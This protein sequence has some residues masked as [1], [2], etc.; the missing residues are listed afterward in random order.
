MDN[1]FDLLSGRLPN[2]NQ[3]EMVIIVDRYNR[4]NK[5]LVQDLGFTGDDTLLFDTLLSLDIKWVPNHL[6]YQKNDDFYEK[7]ILF[8][9]LIT[10]IPN[11][12]TLLVFLELKINIILIYFKVVF[13]THQA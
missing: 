8:N 5:D 1:H 2:D 13:I 3:Q 9:F 12:L 4:L 11:Q 6:L 10:L 7:M